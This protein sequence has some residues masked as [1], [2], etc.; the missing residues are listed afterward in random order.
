MAIL[1]S[2]LVLGAN[3]KFT[4]GREVLVYVGT[5]GPWFQFEKVD[6]P[7]VIWCEVLESDLCLIDACSLLTSSYLKFKNKH[8]KNGY[9][10]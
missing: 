8:L 5:Y 1:S 2:K 10:R 7:G 3:Y 6:E 9:E 4:G